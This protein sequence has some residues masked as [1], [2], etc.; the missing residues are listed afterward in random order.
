[1]GTLETCGR[2][3]SG[4]QKNNRGFWPLCKKEQ[5]I[6]PEHTAP[7]ERLHW[8]YHMEL[9]WGHKVC[10]TG[11]QM[12]LKTDKTEKNELHDPSLAAF[13]AGHRERA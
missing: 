7:V 13:P 2:R 10:S 12:N 8:Q 11:K 1:M 9:N 4:R 6:D 5:S 3:T